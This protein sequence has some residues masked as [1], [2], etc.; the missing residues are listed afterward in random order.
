MVHVQGSVSKQFLRIYVVWAKDKVK[1]ERLG[2]ALRAP[3]D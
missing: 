1:L 3:G 2:Q